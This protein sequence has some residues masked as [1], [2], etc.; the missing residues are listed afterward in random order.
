LHS[1]SNI[2]VGGG[3]ATGELAEERREKQVSLMGS[4]NETRN[5]AKWGHGK[6]QLSNILNWRSA[7][8]NI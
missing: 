6:R 7:G 1:I 4:G 2:A 8:K 5:K 3:I